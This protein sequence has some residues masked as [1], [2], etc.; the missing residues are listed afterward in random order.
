MAQSST[1]I[2]EILLMFGIY[3][4]HLTFRVFLGKQRSD[5]ELGEPVEAALECAV[6]DLEVV[7]CMVAARVG[8][9]VAAVL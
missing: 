6:I 4:V 2:L 3:G 9:I 7:I 1:V 5:E 8:V